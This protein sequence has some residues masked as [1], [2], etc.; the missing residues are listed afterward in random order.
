MEISL[1][2]FEANVRTAQRTLAGDAALMI[3]V[4]ANAYGHGLAKLAPLAIASGASQLAVLD[5]ETG[6]ATRACVPDHPLLCWLL[7]PRDDFSRAVDAS[8]DLGISH[9]WQLEK[10]A[11]EVQGKTA[12]VH[13]KIDT[14]LH[15]NGALEADWPALVSRAREL[16]VAGVLRVKGIWSHL[17]DT[18]IADDKE[19]L[20]RFHRAV[21]IARAA[22]INPTLLHIA[23]SSAAADLAE[24]RLDMVRVGI[25]AYGVSPFDDRS[26]E[27]MGF[28][29]VMSVHS[30]VVSVD[31]VTQTA[32]LGIGYIDG[33]LPLPP[34]TGYVAVD[35]QALPIQSIEADRMVV[36]TTGHTVTVGDT[37]VVFGQPDQGSPKA[38]DWAAW[39]GTIGDEVVAGM[40]PSV[41]RRFVSD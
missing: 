9:L 38:E 18:S 22:G 21:D 11:L 39:G 3:A 10:L 6:I 2:A 12:T 35:G 40:A 13:L 32:M 8:L 1:S 27:E 19:S 23:A 31:P 4:K 24:S 41:P 5:I 26:A 15:R 37:A 33:L 36:T 16:E 14:G 29:P 25:I 17:A 20:E 28:Q 7:S 34:D 30:R